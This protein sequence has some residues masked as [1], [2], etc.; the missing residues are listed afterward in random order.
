MSG[1]LS[2]GGHRSGA[3]S[4]AG[5]GLSGR[6]GSGVHGS[7]S[8]GDGGAG[9]IGINEVDHIKWAWGAFDEKPR[10]LNARQAAR[11]RA[12]VK[13]QTPQEQGQSGAGGAGSGGQGGSA[14]GIAASSLSLAQH[15]AITQSDVRGD[16]LDVLRMISSGSVSIQT[17]APSMTRTMRTVQM[18]NGGASRSIAL[19]CGINK[20]QN[21]ASTQCTESEVMGT[22][23]V[24]ETDNVDELMAA[25]GQND[26][27]KENN[28]NNHEDSDLNASFS[29]TRMMNSTFGGNSAATKDKGAYG[30]STLHSRHLPHSD[31]PADSF[32]SFLAEAK[33]LGVCNRYGFVS[34][35]KAP[36]MLPPRRSVK[37][38]DPSTVTH[39]FAKHNCRLDDS[40]GGRLNRTLQLWTQG[41]GF[42][43]K[44]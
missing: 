27:G 4:S 19:Q 33:Q 13:V 22:M 7:G 21:N 23:L 15:Q 16:L 3:E 1:Y 44:F 6:G 25:S 17:E 29:G 40:T 36:F 41:S 35:P 26:G 37:T 31:I 42:V 32:P 43:P 24:D 38:V 5:G 30:G 18:E 20:Q 12:Q 28:Q 34:L 8:F 14:S 11:K 2:V 10:D 9:G 39:L